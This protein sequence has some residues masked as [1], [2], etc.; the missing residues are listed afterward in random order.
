MNEQKAVAD[1]IAT[2]PETFGLKAFPGSV[3]RIGKRES[4]VSQGTVM[5][6]T[7]IQKEDQWLAFAKGTIGE[8]RS[9]IVKEVA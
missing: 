6:Y 8:L 7:L 3:F 5:L 1:A 2:F 4:F 9:Q